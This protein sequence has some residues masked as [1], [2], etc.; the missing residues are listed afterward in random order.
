MSAVIPTPRL[1]FMETE[2]FE[3]FFD[4]LRKGG[5]ALLH[6]EVIAVLDGVGQAE[7]HGQEEGLAF[8]TNKY[9]GI[10]RT[11][12]NFIAI[13]QRINEQ[14]NGLHTTIEFAHPEYRTSPEYH[15]WS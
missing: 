14:K 3:E 8:G 5:A 12:S 7:L 9:P 2:D 13:E 10:E 6:S 11:V 4:D 15:I 1:K